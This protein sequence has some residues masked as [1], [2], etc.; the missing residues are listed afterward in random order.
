MVGVAIPVNLQKIELR[1]DELKEL[2][3]KCCKKPKKN[4]KK[5]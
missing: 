3:E 1:L 5:K 2:M 4:G